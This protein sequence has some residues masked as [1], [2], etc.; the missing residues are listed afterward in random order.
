MKRP[1]DAGAFPAVGAR[2]LAL[3]QYTSGST[4]SPKGVALS[5]AN[6]IANI[7]GFGDAFAVNPDDV[8]VT[9]L[10]L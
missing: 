4:G 6:L 5:H 10:P 8:C 2:D 9:W 3:I 1:L 7:R